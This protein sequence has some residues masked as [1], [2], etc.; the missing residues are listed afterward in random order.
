MK[1]YKTTYNNDGVINSTWTGSADAASKDRTALKS[2][3][4]GSKPTTETHDVPTDKT[5]LLGWL[6][7][8]AA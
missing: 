6:N 3:H 5:G 7:K 1:L 4:R 8:H 2:Q